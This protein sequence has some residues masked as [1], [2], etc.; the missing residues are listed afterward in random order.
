MYICKVNNCNKEFKRIQNLVMH[1]RVHFNVK[2]F[3]CQFCTKG[4]TQKGNLEKHMKQHL[5][6]RLLER[7]IMK[8]QYCPSK[9]TESY[10]LMVRIFS[11]IFEV[12]LLVYQKSIAFLLKLIYHRNKKINKEK[13]N[14]YLFSISYKSI[15]LNN[16]KIE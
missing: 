14:N 15:S 13:S 10:N 1:L 8:C 7:K 9:F 3:F 5:K 11:S 16:F 6:P 12:S 4:F 2:N